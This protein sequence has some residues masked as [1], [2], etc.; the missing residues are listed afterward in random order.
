MTSPPP[1]FGESSKR[2]AIVHVLTRRLRLLSDA[3]AGRLWFADAKSPR[4]AARSAFQS[5]ANRGLV[6]LQTAM[7][8]PELDLQGPLL[9]WRP[10]DEPP[11]FGRLSFQLKSRWHKPP[12]RTV[13]ASA[14]SQAR[15]LLGAP[16]GG[17]PIRPCELAHD[18]GLATVFFCLLAQCPATLARW[19]HEDELVRDGRFR[20]G[21]PIPDALLLGDPDVVVE[22]GGEY[23]AGKLAAQAAYQSGPYQIW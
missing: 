8:H 16:L 9:D 12:E 18:L 10:G 1:M 5:L 13:V 2:Q 3:Q 6:A 20:A 15:A 4:N 14:T 23:S 7:V 21:D 19:R 22:F 11:H 17:R